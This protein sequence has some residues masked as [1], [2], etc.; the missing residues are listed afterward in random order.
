MK[1]FITVSLGDG[2]Q[3]NKCTLRTKSGDFVFDAEH[4]QHNIDVSNN[5]VIGIGDAQ[6]MVSRGEAEKQIADVKAEAEKQIA[7]VKAE[8]EKQI[9]A[10]K[11]AN[12]VV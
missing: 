1:L 4:G 5:A 8:A 3:G 2:E 12:P 10:A 7:D 9:A 11:A 6:S